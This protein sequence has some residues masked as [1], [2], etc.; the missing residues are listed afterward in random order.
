MKRTKIK[1][2]IEKQIVNKHLRQNIPDTTY[3][4]P[5][6]L[7]RKIQSIVCTQTGIKS[8][9][10]HYKTRKEE[11]REARQL[12][13]YFSAK[14]TKVALA[15][16]GLWVGNKTHATVLNSNKKINNL[17]QTKRECRNK[18]REMEKEIITFYKKL[19]NEEV[20]SEL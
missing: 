4:I 14:Y 11:I 9:K 8:E 19:K 17:I 3:Y 12:I 7:I 15:K 5:N 18:I 10:I 2:N 20:H 1:K 13:H 6:F 16:I